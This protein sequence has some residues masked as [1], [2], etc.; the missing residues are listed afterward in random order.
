MF[1]VSLSE[2]FIILVVAI[3]V[4]PSKHWPDV[5]RF[6]AKTV[7]FIRSCVW[8]ISDM[9]EKIQQQIELEKPIDDLIRT[10]TKDV[11]DDFS[12]PMK[13]KRRKGKAEK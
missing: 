9:S 12:V 4:I 2:F 1:G 3:L 5:A 7:K 8:K 13:K 10:T 11:L 6:V